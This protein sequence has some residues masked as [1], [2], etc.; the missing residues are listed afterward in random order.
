VDDLR[1]WGGIPAVTMADHS[2]N[3][4]TQG[5]GDIGRLATRGKIFISYRRDD[6]PGDA[7]GVCNRLERKFGKANVFMDVD[8]LVAGQRFDRELDK[9]LSQCDVLVA[10]IG[11][12]WM[13][14]LAQHAHGSERDFVHDEIAAALKRDIVVIPALI[15]REGHMPSLRQ[16]NDLPEEIRELILYQKHDIAHESFNRDADHLTAAIIAVLGGGRG[17]TPWKAKALLG[18]I[19]LAL[20]TA[21]LGYWMD[22]IPWIG[23]SRDAGRPPSGHDN[24]YFPATKR[25]ASQ[26]EVD[27][28]KRSGEVKV[29]ADAG[30]KVVDEAG[31]RK[32][33]A[34]CDR[35]A[36]SPSDTARPAGVA[37]ID[38]TKIDTA[39]ATQAC[40]A[41]MRRYPDMDR[42]IFQAG[43]VASA[44]KDDARAA[45]LYRAA[46]DKGNVAAM[47]NLGV[48]YNLG[49]GVVQ[50]VAEARKWYESAAALGDV[51]AMYN[52][53]LIYEGLA[54]DLEKARQWYRKAADMGDKE[55]QEKLK[56]LK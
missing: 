14:S 22:V 55:A 1:M 41:A 10:I 49:N 4:A 18:A 52:L 42:F 11:P 56:N 20:A 30:N 50:D 46:A 19:G 37:G 54:K 13:E 51:Y 45:G 15:G 26:V 38:I 43:R 31:D 28:S 5:R 39:A 3:I 24:P 44:R 29:D 36:A 7:R 40:D 34:D 53:G 48:L 33:A 32:A 8:R 16:R 35:L 47:V 9:A 23:P 21:L 25:G 17:R 2:A 6:V 27:L 12:R